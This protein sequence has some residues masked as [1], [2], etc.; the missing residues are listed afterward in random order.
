MRDR[1]VG[2]RR[3]TAGRA[4]FAAISCSERQHLSLR[5]HASMSWR[6][7][8]DSSEVARRFLK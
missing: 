4:L 1:R 6:A 3:A 7:L 8:L 5:A 2:G